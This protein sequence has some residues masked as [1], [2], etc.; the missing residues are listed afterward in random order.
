MATEDVLCYDGTEWVSLKGPAGDSGGQLPSAPGTPLKT[1]LL[2]AYTEAAGTTP[3]KD[4]TVE[5]VV[6][7]GLDQTASPATM[8]SLA[9][10][11]GTTKYYSS[12]VL[13]SAVSGNDSGGRLLFMSGNGISYG[14]DISL[15]C[16]NATNLK[17]G[18]LSAKAGNSPGDTGGGITLT[19]GDSTPY[20]GGNINLY[21]GQGAGGGSIVLR[22][23]VGL[24]VV[25]EGKMS[26]AG[27]VWVVGANSQYGCGSG[28]I[29]GTGTGPKGSGGIFLKTGDGTGSAAGNIDLTAGNSGDASQGGSIICRVG[30]SQAGGPAGQI[31]L[32]GE[33]VSNGPLNL[34]GEKTAREIQEHPSLRIPVGSA[35]A[36]FPYDFPGQVGDM[37][38]SP[39]FVFLCVGTNGTNAD[40]KTVGV[41]R[42][43]RLEPHEAPAA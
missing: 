15:T 7:A 3:L 38:I 18:S 14:G 10:K 28:I 41:W 33:V 13:T 42:K 22:P 24:G 27:G 29:M 40:G 43:L 17:G 4:S 25:E 8:V 9:T 1:D 5:Q 16:G 36:D 30:L 2:K 26:D 35:P 32:W 12:G 20:Q 11:F 23:G 6:L 19:G 34:I 37:R 21:A 31:K 39:D